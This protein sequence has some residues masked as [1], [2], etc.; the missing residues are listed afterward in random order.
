M[1]TG[2]GLR[3]RPLEGVD[4]AHSTDE[5]VIGLALGS[6][7]QNPLPALPA[8]D[9]DY[10][11]NVFSTSSKV[12]IPASTRGT[13]TGETN[14]KRKWSRWKAFGGLFGRNDVTLPFNQLDQSNRDPL[15]K[16]VVAPKSPEPHST[17]GAPK[18]RNANSE[19]TEKVNGQAKSSQDVGRWGLL[20]RSGSLNRSSSR[21]KGRQKS[22]IQET[23]PDLPIPQMP[24]TIQPLRSHAINKDDALPQLGGPSLLQVEIPTVEMERYSVM[25]GDVL[26]P[27]VGP[28]L[29]SSPLV[30]RSRNLEE[31]DLSAGVENEVSPI[32]L[33]IVLSAFS[34]SLAFEVGRQREP[35]R[36]HTI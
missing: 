12:S 2:R 6:P 30:Q 23:L 9:H 11:E 35:S 4:S 33:A 28:K 22:K 36:T 14:L 15:P 5:I 34:H 3:P 16:Q 32:W 31:L 25:F 7:R 10:F 26:Q 13:E 20:S 27:Q 17:S 24:G 29:Q 1:L 21:L 8:E 18:R 19:K